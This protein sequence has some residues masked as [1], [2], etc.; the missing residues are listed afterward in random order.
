MTALEKL[1]LEHPELFKNG[2][3]KAIEGRCPYDFGYFAPRRCARE[4]IECSTCWKCREVDNEEDC[5][6]SEE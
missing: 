3:E 6:K 1:R 4:W 2:Q 5:L